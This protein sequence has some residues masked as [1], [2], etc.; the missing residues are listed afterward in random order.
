MDSYI[1]SEIYYRDLQQLKKD[2]AI[3]FITNKCAKCKHPNCT[4]EDKK[5]CQKYSEYL[6]SKF[7]IP[8][9]ETDLV[10]INNNPICIG[11]I[12]LIHDKSFKDINHRL[13]V[14]TLGMDKSN[15]HGR[16]WSDEYRAIDNLSDFDF[17]IIKSL[18]NL[19]TKSRS[20]AFLRLHCYSIMNEYSNIK[21]LR[22][23]I[24][25]YE[26]KLFDQISVIGLPESIID[27]LSY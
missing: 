9:V 11:D 22:K 18:A 20:I 2:E 6:A 3:E 23:E 16:Y 8:N 19:D 13:G 12:V 26:G 25:Y 1:G 10:D 4:I 5:I 15:P 24:E 7:S 27:H 17:E 14:I 21:H